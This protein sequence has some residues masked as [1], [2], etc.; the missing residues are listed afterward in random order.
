[1]AGLPWSVVL[2]GGVATDRNPMSAPNAH[3][4]GTSKSGGLSRNNCN[5]N[6]LGNGSEMKYRGKSRLSTGFST[7]RVAVQPFRLCKL[8][9]GVHR[10]LAHAVAILHRA[11]AFKKGVGTDAAVESRCRAGGQAVTW[12]CIVITGRYR[13]LVAEEKRAAELNEAT[14]GKL[15]MG[16]GTQIRSYVF[17]D[18]RVK[19]HRTN[20]EQPNPQ[21]VM[22]GDLQGFID[23]ELR[24][25]RRAKG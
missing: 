10:L 9:N 7:R 24:R 6:R 20:Y 11:A 16:W 2:A 17:Y 23:A 3:L 8:N 14:G 21:K 19:D 18:N 13:G 4:A 12:A 5:H 25:R 1:M 15:D 22:D